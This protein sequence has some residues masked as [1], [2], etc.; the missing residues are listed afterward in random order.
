MGS[1]VL[2]LFDRSPYLQSRTAKLYSEKLS[3]IIQFF[4]QEMNKRKRGVIGLE[5][6]RLATSCVS[7]MRPVPLRFGESSQPV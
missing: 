5:G 7:L 1:P 6:I 4:W 3:E 2:L